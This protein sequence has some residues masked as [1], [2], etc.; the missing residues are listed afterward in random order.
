MKR[1]KAKKPYLGQRGYIKRVLCRFNMHDS[2]P[3]NTPL[4]THFR[5]SSALCPTLDDVVAYMNHVPY[6]RVVGSLMYAMIC[7]RRDLFISIL[8]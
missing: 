4:T 7:T 3:L 6:F 5:I 1:R 2:K 8:V